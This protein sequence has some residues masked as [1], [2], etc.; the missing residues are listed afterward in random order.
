MS[1]GLPL[2][3]FVVVA[4]LVALAAYGAHLAQSP[5][6]S[7]L[8]AL[9]LQLE[10]QFDPTEDREHDERFH[11][12]S[13]FDK[14]DSRRAYNTLRGAIDVDGRLWPA[15]GGDY[16]YTTTSGSGKNRTTHTHRLSYL[17]V[18]TPHLSAP[19]LAIR[20]EGLFD[21]FASFMGFDDIDFE[22]HEFSERYHVKSSSKRF[23]YAVIEPRMMEF[24]L[25]HNAPAI[26]FRR[27]Q[28]CVTRGERAWTPE[29][30]AATIH[31]AAEF[32]ARWPEKVA[33]VLDDEEHA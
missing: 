17:I 26:E 25:E 16:R 30:F 28:C 23:A 18:E 1:S 20:R 29:Q 19:D 9:A 11:Y 13:P 21:R 2:L 4:A 15:H 7:Q 32:F 12:F 6:M 10:W 24:L 3:V 5:R 14:G 33:S 8:G 31:W 27:G 22:S